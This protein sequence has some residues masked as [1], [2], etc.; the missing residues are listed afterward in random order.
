MENIL[1]K[2]RE[3]QGMT[4][5]ELAKKSGVARTTISFLETQKKIDVKL[6]T[7]SALA[8]SVGKEVSEVFLI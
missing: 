1:R 6:S 2:C 3:E 4:Q 5:D 8:K 7:L